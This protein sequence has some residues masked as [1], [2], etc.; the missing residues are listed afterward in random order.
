MKL[1]SFI[2][3]VIAAGCL[4]T[5]RTLAGSLDPTNGPGPTMHTLEEIYQ[6]L[7]EVQ[8]DLEELE[9]PDLNLVEL[10]FVDVGDPD[11]SADSNGFGAVAY[12]F[13]IGKYEVANK[14]YARFLNAVD[15]S[16]S[17]VLMLYDSAMAA[18][19]VSGISNSPSATSGDKY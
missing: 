1:F 4:L 2:L 17:N 18:S 5:S 15:P 10:E 7:L 16:G 3:S 11:N 9:T 13:K 19:P 6:K 8:S 12:A 14:D